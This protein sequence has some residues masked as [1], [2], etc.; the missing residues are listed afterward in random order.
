MYPISA[1]WKFAATR[2][3]FCERSIHDSSVFWQNRTSSSVLP[4]TMS[5]VTLLSEQ[6]IN[7]SLGHPEVSMLLIGLS[8]TSRARSSGQLERSMWER[9]HIP[10]FTPMI[11]SEK[12]V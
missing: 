1:F 4:D 6:S 7:L 2:L 12:L 5:S 3:W 10:A 8:M 11:A 9:P